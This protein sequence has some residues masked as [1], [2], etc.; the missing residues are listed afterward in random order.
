MGVLRIKGKLFK[1]IKSLRGIDRAFHTKKD[2]VQDDLFKPSSACRES[3][4]FF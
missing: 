4:V 3:H 2:G 1:M